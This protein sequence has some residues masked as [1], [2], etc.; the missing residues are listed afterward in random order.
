MQC[1]FQKNRVEQHAEIC[2]NAAI[3]SPALKC[4]LLRIAILDF[5]VGMIE[6]EDYYWDH[7]NATAGG[8]YLD[9]KERSI[10]YEFLDNY[11]PRLCLDIA[12][13]S[14]RFS[15]SF[16]E[17][18]ICVVAG[19]RDPVPIKKLQCSLLGGEIWKKKHSYSA[20]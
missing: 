14:G 16:A 12:C 7:C 17:R 11:T 3:L 9:S 15:L 13:G 6:I 2:S 1:S 10:I 8:Q 19:D 18:G 4:K 5:K 20:D